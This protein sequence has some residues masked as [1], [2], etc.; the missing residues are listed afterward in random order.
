[1][2]PTMPKPLRHRYLAVVDGWLDIEVDDAR[3]S[4][5]KAAQSRSK[6]QAD[7]ENP[8]SGTEII[9]PRVNYYII[10]LN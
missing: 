6:R 9:G 2:F 5:I 3:T 8:H 4:G 10:L 1:M 7:P